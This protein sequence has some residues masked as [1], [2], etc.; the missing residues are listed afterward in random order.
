VDELAYNWNKS[1]VQSLHTCVLV[2]P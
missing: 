1:V 2:K